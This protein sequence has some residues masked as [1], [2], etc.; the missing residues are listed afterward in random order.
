M[1]PRDLRKNIYSL[2]ATELQ[3]FIEAVNLLKAN[4]TYDTFVR[5]HHHA[6]MHA[7][8]MPGENPDPNIRNV[9]HRGPAFLAWHRQELRDYELAL[10]AVKPGVT[11]PYWDWAQDAQ[12]PD[13]KTAPLWTNTYIGG[14]GAGPNDFVPNGPFTHWVAL[15]ENT[16]GDL[17]PRSTPGIVR[18]LGRDPQGYPTLPT[19]ADVTN[20]LNEGVYDSA[21]W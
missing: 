15:I 9:A 3:D 20:C 1:D 4:G 8:P 19:Q 6:M 5:R 18:R 7:T 13:P 12:L 17:V 16:A 11:L 14:D 21:P 10:Q 2:S